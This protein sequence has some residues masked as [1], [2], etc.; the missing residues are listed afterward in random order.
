VAQRSDPVRAWAAAEAETGALL[1]AASRQIARSRG[2]PPDEVGLFASPVESADRLPELLDPLDLGRLHEARMLD[3]RGRKATGAFY[4]P[5]ALAAEL[6]RV[7]LEPLLARTA[8]RA[9]PR[10]VDPSCGSGS[11]LVQALRQLRAVEPH[12]SPMELAASIHGADLDPLA[13]ELCADTLWIELGAPDIPRATLRRQVHQGD[14]LVDVDLPDAPTD[15]RPLGWT[16]IVPEGFEV[17]LGNP[18]WDRDEPDSRAFFGAFDPAHLTLVGHAAARSQAEIL[19]SN[20]KAAADWQRRLRFLAERQQVLCARFPGSSAAAKTNAYQRFIALG[21]QLLRPDGRIGYLVPAGLYADRG[22]AGLRDVLFDQHSVDHLVGFQN[23]ARLFPG[24]DRRFK[25]A[26]IVAAKSPPRGPV[27]FGFLRTSPQDLAEGTPLDSRRIRDLSPSS[28]AL[29]EVDDA[30]TFELLARLSARERLGGPAWSVRFRRE[31]DLTTHL[32]RFVEEPS[33]GDLPVFEGRMIDAFCMNAKAWVS[34]RG[35]RAVW[36]TP[37]DLHAMPNSQYWIRATDLPQIDPEAEKPKIG[38]MAIG[39][40]TNTRTMLATVL[41]RTPCGNSVPTLRCR[42]R[43]CGSPGEF[44]LCAVL[45]STVFDW[46]LRLRMAGNNLNRFVLEDVPAPSPADIF[47]VE[48]IDEAV[49]GLAFTSAWFG[50]VVVR[51]G[52]RSPAILCPDRR[53]HVMAV[54]DALVARAYGLSADEYALVLGPTDLPCDRL[55]PA[56]IARVPLPPKG[57]WRVDRDLPPRERR[58]E[59]A[60]AAFR[61]LD[62]GASPLELLHSASQGAGVGR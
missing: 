48:G 26:A 39:S 1:A 36:N 19:G 50:P 30:Q 56:A 11:F 17:V 31:L 5:P 40:A 49:Q 45:N 22:S 13:V 9:L 29:V 41:W 58:P 8:G 12:R 7:T 4:T 35:R 60:R 42:P 21:L 3:A 43:P 61:S 14:A 55:T 52:P 59:L 53:R 25:F 2:L 32:G 47:G 20:P 23:R 44:A 10:I 57:F 34:G 15:W 37:D 18:P 16:R 46:A 33:P 24:V 54:L 51:T 28:G 27:R 38:F 6:T 62:A